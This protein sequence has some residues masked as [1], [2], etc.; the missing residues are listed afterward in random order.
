MGLK[1]TRQGDRL[2]AK[3]HYSKVLATDDQNA[4]AWQLLAVVLIEEG[5]IAEAYQCYERAMDIGESAEILTN[6][7]EVLRQLNRH[8]DALDVATRSLILDP[9]NAQTYYHMG[10]VYSSMNLAQDAIRSYK[11]ALRNDPTFVSAAENL[12]IVLVE[13]ARFEEAVKVLSDT[14]R[15]FKSAPCS[16]LFR[17]AVYTSHK[18]SET[19][20]SRARQCIEASENSPENE[21]MLSVVM[22]SMGA[23]AQVRGDWLSA[24][25][26]YESSLSYSYQTSSM[27]ANYGSL[28]WHT[29]F[30][31]DALT[32]FFRA[33]ALDIN[34]DTA[35]R[36]LGNWYYE[37]GDLS[38]AAL[39]FNRAA[40]ARPD[41]AFGMKVRIACMSRAIMSPCS[42][43]ADFFLIHRST[44][45]L[46]SLVDEATR[47]VI[48]NPVKEIERFPFYWMYHGANELSNQEMLSSIVELA[49]HKFINTSHVFKFKRKN[50]QTKVGFI[51]KFW[52]EE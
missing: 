5:L 3:K 2:E 51:S 45:Q 39:V 36:L 28:L 41:I 40:M 16:L 11:E 29:G 8:Q 37:S 38:K 31:N 20:Y 23:L 15:M 19:A 18:N 24:K 1:F 17:I 9:S 52:H 44:I 12:A 50:E 14:S 7:V 30:R 47:N 33:I 43:A 27:W 35:L 32:S 21:R 26:F 10:L 42:S 22:N 25:K 48:E 6:A 13:G 4:L 34:D 46:K 49:S